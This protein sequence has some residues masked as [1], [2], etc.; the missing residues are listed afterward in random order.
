MKHWKSVLA[1]LLALILAL[2]LCACAPAGAQEMLV[3]NGG[4]KLRIPAEYADLVVVETENVND[5]DQLFSV[6]ETASIEAAKKLHP[7]NVDGVGWLFGIRKISAEN[8]LDMIC[9]DMSGLDIIG[10]DKDGSYYVLGTP[11]DVRFEREDMSNFQPGNEDYENWSKLCAWAGSVKDS[12]CEENGLEKIELTN[13]EA[14]IYLNKLAYF[15]PEDAVFRTLDYG[16]QPLSKIDSTP[17]AQELVDGVKFEWLEY[18]DDDQSLTQAP[19][20]EYYCLYIPADDV[21]LDFFKADGTLV[22]LVNGWG[23]AQLFR[24]NKDCTAIVEKWLA[25]LS[26]AE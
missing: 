4:M 17:Y 16:D 2:S 12:F 26:A 8:Y 19:D 21:R 18:A 7:E 1:G 24:A 6:S 15:D 5:P 25:A 23:G 22:R 11:T 13:T 14:D 3:E 20:G 10:K 9:M